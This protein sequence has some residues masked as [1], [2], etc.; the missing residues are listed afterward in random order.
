MTTIT[1]PFARKPTVPTVLRAFINGIDVRLWPRD[2]AWQTG[3]VI[4]FRTAHAVEGSMARGQK[5]GA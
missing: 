2:A 1:A 4:T 3:R 5:Q